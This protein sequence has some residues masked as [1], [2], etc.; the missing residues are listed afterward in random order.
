LFLLVQWVVCADAWFWS[1][2]GTTTLPPTEEHEGS[3]SPVGS[4]ELPS[5]TR[6]E[7]IYERQGIHT[8]VQTWDETTEAPQL[9]TVI[10]T[11]LPVNERATEKGTARIS[12]LISTPGND[13]SSLKGI[14]SGE[15]YH[16]TGNVSRRRSSIE[17]ELASDTGS[18]HV[19]SSTLM[20]E[21]NLT[22]DNEM[23]LRSEIVKGAVMPTDH[24]DVDSGGR[25]VSQINKKLKFQ[26]RA[27]TTRNSAGESNTK[28]EQS[29]DSHP[30]ILN[31]NKETANSSSSWNYLN[32]TDHHSPNS[33]QTL[34]LDSSFGQTTAVSQDNQ[35]MTATQPP[36]GDQVV[37][38]TSQAP[39]ANQ[40][41]SSTETP[42]K[43]LKQFITLPIK[44]VINLS[45]ATQ[46]QLPSQALVT[47]QKELT[48]HSG[49]NLDAIQQSVSE[50]E[51]SKANLF[52]QTAAGGQTPTENHTEV[53]QSALDSE[54]PECLFL[55]TALPFCSSMV[56]Q[57]FALPNFFN[58]SSV[59]EVRALLNE[60]AWLLGSRCHHSLEWFFCLLLVPK[61]GSVVPLPVLP[62]QSFCQVLRDSCWMLLDEGHLPVECHTL[63][64]EEDDGYQC[65]SVSNQ[66][67]NH[68]FKMNLTGIL[69]ESV[70]EISNPHFF[71]QYPFPHLMNRR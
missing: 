17:S 16:L 10:S 43:I 30:E 3:G 63:P 53:A 45:T 15:S 64:D 35:Q 18:G 29:L 24:R 2:T 69:F 51:L 12:S 14:G 47:S 34:N 49:H 42:T 4:G 6:A 39:F 50:E 9:T 55:D 13:T 21:S 52:S 44:P 58:H 41:L 23:S 59:E 65:L 7:L 36:A 54:S 28:S 56:G 57:R 1:W 5:E 20:S 33:L 37:L 60:W 48:S 40:T 61:C 46:P 19:P 32:L 70:L 66:K 71:N 62:C 8:E 22:T 38:Q 26:E 31:Q 67:G 27:W 25:V 11:T 68:W